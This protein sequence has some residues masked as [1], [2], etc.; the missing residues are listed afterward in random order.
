MSASFELDELA[1]LLWK[2]GD[3]P[4][5]VRGVAVRLARIAAELRDM[6]RFPAAA[7]PQGVPAKPSPRAIRQC[8]RRAPE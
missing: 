3:D 5:F 2:Q 8:G 6:E 1:L 7:G 4:E